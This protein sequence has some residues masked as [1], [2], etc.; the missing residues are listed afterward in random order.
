MRKV[1]ILQARLGSS[2]FPEKVIAEISGKPVI[3]HI[4]DRLAQSQK[5]DEICVAIP[6]SASDDKLA[7]LLEQYEVSVCRGS[8]NDVLSR[9]IQAAYQ[10]RAE[11]I[12]RAKANYPFLDWRL[13]D[14]LVEALESDQEA[15]FC[16]Y[17]DLPY[18]IGTE[19]F[20]LKTLEK[21]DY[22]V[23]HPVLRKNVT[24]YLHENPS[25]FATNFLTPPAGL[26][27]SEL[28]LSMN[29]AEDFKLVTAI[30]DRLYQPGEAIPVDKVLDLLDSDPALQEQAR[31]LA[32]A[33]A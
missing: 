1:A 9:F 4:I 11:I 29:S 14:N 8:E 22:L 6:N 10:T 2:R 31:S 32:V 15:E 3:A 26:A 33:A 23:K 25:P 17:K 30:Y 5:V 28:R 16:S 20:R 19:V 24:R 12:V 7:A 21:L 18:G 27:R 13:M